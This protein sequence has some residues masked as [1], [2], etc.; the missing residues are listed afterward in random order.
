MVLVDARF[1]SC[2]LQKKIRIF[3]ILAGLFFFFFVTHSLRII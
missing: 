2:E 3:I 1:T